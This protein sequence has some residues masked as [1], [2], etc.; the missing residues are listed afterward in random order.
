MSYSQQCSKRRRINVLANNSR[1][2]NDYRLL[3]YGF[4]NGFFFFW[5][6]I[7]SYSLGHIQQI[8]FRFGS[9]RQKKN[10]CVKFR[11]VL[12]NSSPMTSSQLNLQP[13]FSHGVGHNHK[14]INV[15]IRFVSKDECSTAW[16][17]NMAARTGRYNNAST[18]SPH[19]SSFIFLVLYNNKCRNRSGA[20][21]AD[22]NVLYCNKHSFQSRKT[23]IKFNEE[24]G[25]MALTP[26]S[27]V[28]YQR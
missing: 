6:K 26:L 7:S 3:L 17:L 14:Y 1:S 27:Y 13:D 22:K 23:A 25:V 18:L 5:N 8:R 12:H 4:I 2:A 24:F 9:S 20:G 16:I 28:L 11:S 19:T 15:P 21:A 10:L